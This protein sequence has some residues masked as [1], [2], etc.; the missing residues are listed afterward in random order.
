MRPCA[1]RPELAPPRP[2]PGPVPT[3]PSQGQSI[4]RKPHRHAPVYS[5]PEATEEVV[6]AFSQ[7]FSPFRLPQRLGDKKPSTDSDLNRR[8]NLFMPPTEE[9]HSGAR[10]AHATAPTKIK[11]E[12]RK[13]KTEP[14]LSRSR[15]GR[16]A[17]GRGGCSRCTGATWHRAQRGGTPK[18]GARPTTATADALFH[19]GVTVKGKETLTFSF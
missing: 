4:S 2:G 15:P 5:V 13:Q 11:P 18:I 16:G 9:G 7:S 10:R 8:H 19:V 1:R 17:R 12:A 3:G 14:A 6:D